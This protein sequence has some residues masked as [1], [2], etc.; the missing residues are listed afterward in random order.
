M[1]TIDPKLGNPKRMLNPKLLPIAALVLVVLAL[2]FM[3]TPLLRVTGSLQGNGNI[4]IQG[5]GQS[6]PPN[7]APGGG[8]VQ[9]FFGGGNG[10]QGQ[11][12]TLGSGMLGGSAGAIFYF[13]LVLVSLPA[14][15]GMY[16]TKRWGQ[17]FGIIIAVIYGLLGLLSLIPI[18][19]ISFQGIRSPLGLFLGF[20]HVSLAVAVIVLAA[21]P[22]KKM[23]TPTVPVTTPAING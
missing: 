23:P 11:R 10:S 7:V 12:I 18:L 19:L 8:T 4:V 13:V 21:F 20:L 2:L 22:A 17:V 1:S 3:A 6:G 5:N 15:A 9:R 14:A 16:L